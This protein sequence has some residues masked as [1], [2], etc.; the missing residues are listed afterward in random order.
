[1]TDNEKLAEFVGLEVWGNLV[2]KLQ[3][4][5]PISYYLNGKKFCEIADWNPATKPE[6]WAMVL[7]NLQTRTPLD[8]EFYP[9]GS[10]SLQLWLWG[11][12]SEK[13]K[14]KHYDT[15]GQ[16]VCNAALEITKRATDAKD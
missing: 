8:I 15:I 14:E 10:C 16:A 9:D 4:R 3:G 2:D 13:N 5:P 12:G 1:M 6:Q 11:R 7:G